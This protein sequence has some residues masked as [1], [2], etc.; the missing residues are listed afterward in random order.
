MVLFLTE[1][2]NVANDRCRWS[3][4]VILPDDMTYCLAESETLRVDTVADN[5]CRRATEEP[6]GCE[7]R[8]G[9]VV[10]GQSLG[11][12]SLKNMQESILVPH[13]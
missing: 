4:T 9:K 11:N 12:T 7:G 8:T 1:S 2:P 10:G 6:L 5:H 3:D 13:R